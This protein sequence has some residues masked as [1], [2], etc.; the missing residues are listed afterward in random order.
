MPP[1]HRFILVALCIVAL[2]AVLATAV[3]AAERVV[4]DTYPTIQAAINAASPGDS[5]RVRPGEYNEALVISGKTLTPFGE[6]APE[7]TVLTTNNT[8]RICDILAGSNVTISD[9]SFTRG[10]SDVGGAIRVAASQLR[11]LRCS[12]SRNQIFGTGWEGR[13]GA[14]AVLS[15]SSLALE[16]SSF[17]RNF[18]GYDRETGV[19]GS[20]GAVATDA[21][22]QF[23]AH[24]Y[25]FTYNSAAGFEGGIG[26][27]ICAD[28]SARVDSCELTGNF[29]DGAIFA[30]GPLTV[31][32]CTFR[33]NWIAYGSAGITTLPPNHTDSL[34]VLGSVFVD[35]RCNFE[36]LINSHSPSLISG[37]TFAFTEADPS[38]ISAAD[39][40]IS[41]NIVAYNQGYGISSGGKLSCNVVWQNA[42]GNYASGTDSLDE[43][44]NFTADP[45]FC[46][47]GGRDLRIRD[48]SPC[49]PGASL[50]G[51]IG[52]LPVHCTVTA[53]PGPAEATER[54]ALAPI[55][56]NP[57]RGLITLEFTLS[58]ESVI[59]LELLDVTGRHI[60]TLAEGTFGV[61][62][63][64][65]EAPR[66][67]Q[68][69]TRPGVYFARLV[70]G[71]TVRSRR[72]VVI[73]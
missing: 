45:Q 2:A 21:G 47:L 51:L 50:C 8:A 48:T 35:N 67:L 55:R 42:S 69:A 26:G 58:R 1:H 36:P 24:G 63:H 27:A 41:G 43:L 68:Q 13:G 40:L 57:T 56:P 66:E 19:I 32:G 44:G 61:G 60:V 7:S 16:S 23:T 38:V 29:G 53:V 70:S 3:H 54:I 15:G 9:L 52:A 31:S 28:G 34:V 33:S 20:G 22:T 12:L 46:S 73:E 17:D 64:L 65:A 37:N 5:V 18:A 59:R 4:P 6:A 11:M 49:A 10:R 14:I 25:S 39:A 62:T 72:F 71:G 30:R